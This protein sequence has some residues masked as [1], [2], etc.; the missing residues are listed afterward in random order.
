MLML[1]LIYI[2]NFLSFMREHQ[3]VCRNNYDVS[4]NIPRCFIQTA[5]A[6]HPEATVEEYYHRA[7]AISFLE[8]LIN[9]IKSSFISH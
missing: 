1:V 2:H 3:D 9:E 5:S 8:H 6:N 7:L 4:V